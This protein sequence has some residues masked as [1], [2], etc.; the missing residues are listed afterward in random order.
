MK[1]QLSSPEVKTLDL[2]RILKEAVIRISGYHY[3][4]D[5]GP[6]VR[7]RNHYVTKERRCTCPRGT[8]CPA[9]SAVADYLRKGGERAPEPPHGFYPYAPEKCPVCGSPA[10][11]EPKLSSRRRL[12]LFQ[13]RLETLLPRPRANSQGSL[14][15]E[16]LA[17]PAGCDP[18]WAA[19]QRLGRRP[20]HRHRALPWL[21]ARRAGHRRP[22][23]ISRIITCS[24][25]P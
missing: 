19:T 5:F 11:F 10:Y 16:S 22:N 21:V 3:V 8:D 1:T 4:V 14:G 6:D 7:P 12:G 15:Y 17:F 9:V 23:R 13:N 25:F 20:A 24:L 18:R 2:N